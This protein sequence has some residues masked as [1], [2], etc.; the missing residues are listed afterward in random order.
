[1][2]KQTKPITMNI[3][4]LQGT[5]YNIHDYYNYVDKILDGTIVSCD[6]IYLACKRFKEWFSRDDIYFDEKDVDKRIKLIYMMKHSTGD[7]AHKNFRL[8]PWQQW[9][10]ASIFGWKYKDTNKRVTKNVFI[11]CTRKNGKTALAA[12]IAL[13]TLVN[14][15][16]MGQEIYCIANSSKQASI[17]LT[18]T[19]NFAESIDPEGTFFKQYRSE[20]KIPRMKSTI[21]VL[22]SDAMGND[23]YNPSLFIYDEIHA[24]PT[25]DQYEVMKSGQAMRSQ[26]LAITITTSG[27]LIGDG[28]PCYDMWTSCTRMLKGEIEDD[29]QFAAIYQLDEGDD[30]HDETKWEKATPSL[31]VTV[32]MDYMRERVSTADK[33]SS[34]KPL[35][36]TKQFNIW[37]KD[38]TAW[39]SNKMLKECSAPFELSDII[40]GELTNINNEEVYSYLGADLSAVADI[41]ALAAMLKIN[42][43]YYFKAWYF[44]PEE[45]LTGN[46]NESY[47]RQWSRDGHLIVT[48]GNVVDYDY[49]RGVMKDVQDECP[50]IHVCYDAWNSTQWAI[51][52]T[53]EGYPMQPFSQS[54]GNF[55]RT[56][57]EFERLIRS[58][59]VVIDDNPITRWM[60][61][62]V[63][64]KV[65]HNENCKPIKEGMKKK[66]KIDGVIAILE[67]LGGYLS[68]CYEEPTCEYI[69]NN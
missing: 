50:I 61:S 24:S 38:L 27:F 56:V 26:P 13:T 42:D 57:K 63:E 47:Y 25:W 53:E 68:D 30:W 32:R 67:A 43:T 35:I 37:S 49:I 58:G 64:L 9:I 69:T 54:I 59:K 48:D 28:Y 2:T 29:S 44:L 4:Y 20:I 15:K 51:D 62:N 10:I 19:M 45:S 40:N 6:T 14:D 36:L 21:N 18:Q 23:G 46:P 3:K 12:A 33:N 11:M 5:N 31:N 52:C 1:M 41:T 34:Q 65:D 55:S 60:F 66:K 39:I 17:A 16:E 8:L 7:F 22:S